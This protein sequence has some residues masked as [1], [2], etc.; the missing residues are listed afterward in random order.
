MRVNWQVGLSLGAAREK[1]RVAKALRTLPL[2]S[3]S[4]AKGT[5]SY[6][7]VRAL[8]R[9]ASAETEEMLLGIAG[10]GTAS[11]V[12]KTVRLL[13]GA[14]PQ[15]EREQA[16]SD[17]E[18]RYATVYVDDDGM[19]VLRARLPA[20]LGAVVKKALELEA[21]QIMAAV[22]NAERSDAELEMTYA[23]AQADALG[24]LAQAG[25]ELGA[26]DSKSADR[27]QVVVHVDQAVLAGGTGHCGEAHGINVPAETLRRVACD[28]SLVDVV[29]DGQTGVVQSVGRKSRKPSVALQRA[30]QIRDG[31][32]QFSGCTATKY[33]DAHHI[34]HWADGG[35][36]HLSNLISLCRHHHRAV[37]EG[38]FS[39]EFRDNRPL[40]RR[41]DGV[42]LPSVAEMPRALE[43]PDLS[44]VGIDVDTSEHAVW[45]GETMDYSMAVEALLHAQSLAHRHQPLHD[46]GLAP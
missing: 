42:A 21:E 44:K 3:A 6:S 10:N 39:V 26:G 14:N 45:G 15:E 28:A 24:H 41:P 16:H 1:V 32:C 38:G 25:I 40:F 43:P 35:E 18:S 13:K 22:K 5:I 29:H 27:Y 2:V 7:K 30:L 34:R 33:V 11:H 9:V 4:M 8:T 19:V 23:Q 12:E 20:E 31:G 36:T 46:H 17:L 37:H